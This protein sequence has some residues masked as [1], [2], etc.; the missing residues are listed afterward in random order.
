MAILK[1]F[2]LLQYHAAGTKPSASNPFE[3]ILAAAEVVEGLLHEGTP[4]DPLSPQEELQVRLDTAGVPHST[5]DGSDP[6]LNLELL[7][8]SK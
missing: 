3:R 7:E 8:S 5:F 1:I 4:E 6:P 2:Q